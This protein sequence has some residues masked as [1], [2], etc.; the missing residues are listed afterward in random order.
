M[1][2]FI[3][4]AG[5]LVWLWNGFEVLKGEGQ[6]LATQGAAYFYCAVMLTLTGIRQLM[7][8]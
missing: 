3:L 1:W 7:E 5:A 6:S 4:F 8:D 2:S